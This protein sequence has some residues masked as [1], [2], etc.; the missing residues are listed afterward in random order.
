MVEKPVM[1]IK[2]N[3]VNNFVKELSVDQISCAN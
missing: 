2:Y 3:P 1:H